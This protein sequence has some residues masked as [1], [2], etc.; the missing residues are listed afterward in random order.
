MKNKII[1]TLILTCMILFVSVCSNDDVPTKS[2][3][4][5]D[6][7]N[8]IIDCVDK[9]VVTTYLDLKNK[10]AALQIA[11]ETF[12]N[13]P[14]QSNLDTV[15]EA[16]KTAR[17]PWE[18]SEAF[19][20][21]PVSFLSIDP[22]MDTWPL[23]ESQLQ[24]VLENENF[25]LTPEFLRNGL[26]YSLRGYH[27]IEYLV[28]KD[29]QNRDA[30][31]FEDREKE[32][33]LSASI[34]LAEDA[35]LIYGE[36]NSGFAEEFKNAGN[37]GSRYSSKIQAVLEIVDGIIT[38]AD[39]VGNGKIGEPYATKDV[40]TVESQFSW[41]SLTDFS[42]NI[43]SIKNTYTGFYK[44]GIDGS[45]LD[46]FVK[47]RSAELNSRITA[48]IDAAI[49]AI[50]AIPS[51]FRNNLNADLQIQAAIDACNAIFN[52]FQ[53]EVKPMVSQ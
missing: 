37:S 39:E 10:T 8:I 32:Y 29:G 30:S 22:S 41:N 20:F 50:E 48:E 15:C 25:D 47:S 7:S 46:D 27:A 13:D 31:I 36:W 51:P 34:V 12:S 53:S 17:E 4:T 49:N 1:I 16:W 21:G 3:N 24:S 45:G 26:G 43:R 38:I 44:N 18:K 40:L 52:T 33:L 5:Y 9:V 42:N 14:S 19:L 28:F 23:D 11:C 35:N 6:F 2:D